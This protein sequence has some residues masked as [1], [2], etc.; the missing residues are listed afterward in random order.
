MLLAINVGNTNIRFGVYKER[1]LIAHWKLATNRGWTADEFGMYFVNF[2][3]YEKL[4]ISDVEAVIISSVVPPIM[5]SFEHAIERYMKKDP[6]IIGPGIKTGINIKYEN[7]RELG[8]DRIVNAVAAYELYGG[9]VIVVDFGTATTFNAISSRGEFLGGAICP[10][11]LISAEALYQRTAKLPRIDLAKHDAVIGRNTSVSMQSG[12]FHGYVGQI[13]HIV[14]KIK[15]EMKED[16]IKV[17]ATGGLAKFI[18]P[19]TESIDEVNGRLVLEGLRIIY[20]KN[21]AEA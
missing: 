21:K 7:P 12:I 13:N 4:D 3:N 6:I 5:F 14:S 18:A 15:Q 9:P 20:E 16:N 8:A 17:I 19:E 10:G 2:F 1:K 11:I